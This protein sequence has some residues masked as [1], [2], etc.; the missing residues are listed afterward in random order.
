VQIVSLKSL[1]QIDR[2]ISG[3]ENGFADMP[4]SKKFL[5]D[6]FGYRI[7]QYHPGA[8][9][10]IGKG[11]TN[12][13]VLIIQPTNIMPERDA[14]TGALKK[15]NMLEDA[16]RATAE[17][18]EGVSSKNNR[19]YLVEL[20]DIVRPRIVVTCGPVAMSILRN[21]PVKSF[22]SGRKFSIN[23]MPDYTFFAVTNPTDYGFAR[24]SRTLKERGKAEWAQL[25]KLYDEL[26][27]KA[28]KA[29]WAL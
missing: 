25:S 11:N 28:E 9:I 13:G 14:I 17:I 21:R 7:S 6:N 5:V 1:T 16:Y 23:N 24:A 26:K 18:V 10:Q 22:R 15:F 27:Q 2:D 8:T 3:Q 12:G 20:I 19:A 29:R 4:T